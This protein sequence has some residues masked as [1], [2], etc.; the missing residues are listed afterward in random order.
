MKEAMAH[1]PSLIAENKY[2]SSKPLSHSS[3]VLH[4]TT[5]G[6]LM[7]LSLTGLQEK[8][9]RWHNLLSFWVSDVIF[10]ML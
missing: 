6:Q 8:S 4:L 2:S 10:P 3:D 7:C 5:R 9:T 1:C